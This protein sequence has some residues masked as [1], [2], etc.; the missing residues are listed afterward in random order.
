MKKLETFLMLIHKEIVKT[1]FIYDITVGPGNKVKTF[2]LR[3][4]TNNVTFN[5]QKETEKLVSDIYS[6]RD[7]IHYIIISFRT[8]GGQSLMQYKYY[9]DTE[10]IEFEYSTNGRYENIG[11]SILKEFNFF[12]NIGYY[13]N[14]DHD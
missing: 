13:D 14:A 5:N 11:R 4:N 6:L 10:E 12:I 2:T 1:Y 9:F 8:T 7:L 3:V